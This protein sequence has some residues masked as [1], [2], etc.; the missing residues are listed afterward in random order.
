MPKQAWISVRF[1][2]LFH[3]VPKPDWVQKYSRQDEGGIT[4]SFLGL[5]FN[6]HQED[7]VAL[8]EYERT[9]GNPP[10][11]LTQVS[12]VEC[13]FAARKSEVKKALNPT[14]GFS[15]PCSHKSA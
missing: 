2:A 10:F 5:S 15:A 3:D 11:L 7:T 12:L 8:A 1:P 13:D 6:W 9:P 14:D 4:L